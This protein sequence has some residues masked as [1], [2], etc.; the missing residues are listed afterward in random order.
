MIR[1]LAPVVAANLVGAAT[2]AVLMAAACLALPQPAAAEQFTA[3]KPSPLKQI[4][5]K[6]DGPVVRFSGQAEI[7]GQFVVIWELVDDRRKYRRV[8]FAPDKASSALLPRVAGQEPIKELVFVNLDQAALM[9]LDLV[10]AQ[11][12]LPKQQVSAGGVATAVIRD[13]Q[14]VTECDQRW[15]VAKLVAARKN[16]D[17]VVSA[18]DNARAGC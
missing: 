11:A 8:T 4:R 15:Y 13:Y 9:L 5:A 1:R 2:I 6:G 3:D 12:P 14:A 10:S 18:R 16:P 17:L 7:S